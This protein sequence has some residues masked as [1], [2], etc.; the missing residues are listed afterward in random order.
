[1]KNF[2]IVSQHEHQIPMTVDQCSAGYLIIYI[3]VVFCL[4]VF[5]F[6]YWTCVRC[7][8]F[9]EEIGGKLWKNT[10]NKTLL[11]YNQKETPRYSFTDII[12]RTRQSTPVF[13]SAS[14]TITQFA[15][16]STSPNNH[17]S[18]GWVFEKAVH[19]SDD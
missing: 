16:G 11:K 8:I 2:V 1:M 7:F 13:T 15:L 6:K 17:F 5:I 3:R 18:S 14:G 19:G 12:F 10:W 4:F 9:N